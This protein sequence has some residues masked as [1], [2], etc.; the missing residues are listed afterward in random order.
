MIFDA[1]VV[2][3]LKITSEVEHLS[4]K[5]KMLVTYS[6]MAIWCCWDNT[7]VDTISPWIAEL[8]EQ[9]SYHLLNIRL[10]REYGKY[11]MI[12]FLESFYEKDISN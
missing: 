5:P 8:V 11:G 4:V 6:G 1:E 7:N 2:G 10:Y 9:R 12:N 3:I